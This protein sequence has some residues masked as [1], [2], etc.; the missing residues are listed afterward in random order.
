MKPSLPSDSRLASSGARLPLTEGYADQPYVVILP[1][2]TWLCLVTSADGHE[3][4]SS[5]GVF[6]LRSS[7]QGK[8]WSTPL[9]LEQAGSPENSYAVGLVTPSG[10]VYAFYNFNTEN[11]REVKTEDGGVFERV[12]S[13]GDYV[14]RYSD[15]GGR[16]WSGQRHT[17]PVREFLCDRNNVYGGELRFF[18]NVG[19]PC[20]RA[21]GEVVIPLHKVGA[22]GAGF[23]ALSEGAF[24]LSKNLLTE[25]D[26][27]KIVF[28]TLPD[29]E[30][31]LSTPPGGGR[32]AEEHSVVELSDGSLYCVYRSVDGWPVFSLSRDGGHT[33]EPPQ[34][35][36]FTPGGRRMKNPRA[37]NFVWKLSGGRY[38]YWFHN[39]GGAFIR[40]LGGHASLPNGLS[41]VSGRSPYDDR[42]PVW[43]CAGREIDG[44]NGKL[45]AW[46]QPEILLYDDDPFIRMS[47][48]DLIEQ[49]GRVW[50][51]E[52]DKFSARVH[53]IQ[54]ELLKEMFD[55]FETAR[56][57]NPDTLVR[58]G[59]PGETGWRLAM[60]DLPL[61]IERDFTSMDYRTKDLRGGCTLELAIEGIP[62]PGTVLFDSRNGE[63]AGILL[64]ALDD[65]VIEIVLSDA[66]CTSSWTSDAERLLD[67]APNHVCIII[68]GG[69]KLI[70][71]VINGELCDGG[72]ERQFGWGRYNPNL[73]Q[74]NGAR[75]VLLDACVAEAAIYGRALRVSEAVQNSCQLAQV[76]PEAGP[77]VLA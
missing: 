29:G 44:P 3:G 52:T 62:E 15:D 59:N 12:D 9:R 35:K 24:I 76:S 47:Y 22:M 48:P 63:G 43:L 31:G 40:K 51:T 75:E 53:E 26:P 8:T 28:E 6:T 5:Q 74:L 60:P 55:Q 49:D 1:D 18:W 71:F 23:F 69:P 20:I 61:L 10:R 56:P 32:V 45:L 39:H 68:D 58:A 42:N 4:S 34:Y 27:G 36:T 2:G 19:R 30:L 73:Q 64:R 13:L 25:S 67:G 21:N 37:A 66:R 65:A 14:F 70:L 38:L 7:D 33:W 41:P 50:V 54:P 77:L 46:S 11:V 17:V 72:E 16:T 57:T